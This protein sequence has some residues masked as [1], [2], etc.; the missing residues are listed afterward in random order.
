MKFQ[1]VFS[2][3]S[4]ILH[5]VWR[6]TFFWRLSTDHCPSVLVPILDYICGICL[7]LKGEIWTIPNEQKQTLLILILQNIF[8]PIK[9]DGKYV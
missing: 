5:L 9:A 3:T 8:F 6:S 1:G 4:N 2:F 7:N